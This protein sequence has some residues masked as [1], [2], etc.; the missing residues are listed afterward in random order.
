MTTIPDNNAQDAVSAVIGT[1]RPVF[2][3]NYIIM[4]EFDWDVS[5]TNRARVDVEMAAEIFVISVTTSGRNR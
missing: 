1:R 5:G 3:A 2:I 4:S